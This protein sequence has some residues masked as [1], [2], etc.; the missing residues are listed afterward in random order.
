MMHDPLTVV[1]DRLRGRGLEPVASGSGHSCRCPSHEDGSPS[2][3]IGIGDDG[4]VL[5]HCH[6]GCST[7]A[8]V[9]SRGLEAKDLFP[10]SASA[11]TPRRSSGRPAG[12]PKQTFPTVEAAVADVVRYRGEPAGRWEYHDADGR[13]V[14]LVVRWNTTTGKTFLPFTL[15]T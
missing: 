15:T 10:E 5:L 1:L 11:S 9:E 12:K 2:L 8:V 7:G 14:G 4:R 3:T 6:A 13:L